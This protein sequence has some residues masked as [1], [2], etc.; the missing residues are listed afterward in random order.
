MLKSV[1][2]GVVCASAVA[3]SPQGAKAPSKSITLDRRTAFS[4]GIAAAAGVV[5]QR[6]NAVDTDAYEAYLKAKAA[7]DLKNSYKK[8]R[9]EN[10]PF[11][12]S[13]RTQFSQLRQAHDR[14]HGPFIR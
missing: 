3:L 5:S 1:I 13:F 12:A 9:S 14:T 2:L 7:K 11:L 10:Q 4:A 6:V 8:K